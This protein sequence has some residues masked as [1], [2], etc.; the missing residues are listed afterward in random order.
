MKAKLLTLFSVI[1]MTTVFFSCSKND[2]DNIKPVDVPSA[3]TAAFNNAYPNTTPKWSLNDTYYVAEF[4]NDNNEVDVWFT[5]DGTIMLTVKEIPVANMP[6]AIK[7]AIQGTKYATW[8]YD[9]AKLVQRKGFDDLYKVEMDDPKS[10]SDVTLYYTASGVLIKEVPDID[11][12]PITPAVVPQKI[13]DQLDQYFPDKVY[14]IL[15]FDYEASTKTYEVDIIEYNIPIE[16]VFNNSQVLVYWEWETTYA[17]VLD[18]FKN[19][20][21]YL[22]YTVNQID[23]IYYRETPDASPRENVSTYV[24]EIE[25]NNI[26]RQIIINENGTVLSDNIM[27]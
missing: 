13:I 20:Y 5:A 25:V 4:G 6:A 8:T 14:K 7:T 10:D 24:F 11:N 15:D 1:L 19:A 3:V 26:D 23:D 22:G 2:D 12:T 17:K 16:V 18:F 9:D 27:K 21:L